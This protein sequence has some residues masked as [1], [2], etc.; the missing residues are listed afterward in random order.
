MANYETLKAAINAVIKANG[1]REIT[2]TVLNQTLNAMVNSLGANYQL[3]G[4]ATPST[5]PG[6]PDQNVFYL[7][8]EDGTYTNFNAI[9]LPDGISILMWNGSWSS[10]TFYTI[11][12]TPTASSNNLVSS[13]A[14]FDAIKTDGSAYD[15]SAHF[16][17]GG[18]NNDGKFTL[19]YILSN[20]NTL[21]P[22][23][24]RKGGMSI[25]FVSSS[26]NKY[27]QYMYI[28]TSIAVADFTNT[29]NWEKTNL[30]KEVK[31]IDE[32]SIILDS[33][34]QSPSNPQVGHYYYSAGKMLRRILTVSSGAIISFEKKT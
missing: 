34:Y 22:T 19:E 6:T 28:G 21:I 25:R 23:A 12:A 7:A 26:D 3:A 32:N 13:G 5:N 1:Q 16:P 17:T 27:V 30:E 20:V 2:G 29:A 33:M 10:Q 14:V 15:V 31:K 18:P 8:F 24:W 11:D 9:V 4:V